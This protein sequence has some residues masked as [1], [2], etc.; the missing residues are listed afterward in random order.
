MPFNLKS[1]GGKRK[2]YS[3]E[4]ITFKQKHQKVC[5]HQKYERFVPLK[6]IERKD[7]SSTTLCLQCFM[8]ELKLI[9]IAP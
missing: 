3:G 1:S 4:I 2:C 8:F 7:C 9:T 5:Q 6:N